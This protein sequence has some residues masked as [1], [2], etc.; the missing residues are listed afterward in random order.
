MLDLAAARVLQLVHRASA[1]TPAEI[2]VDAHHALARRAAA[3][4]IVL[5]RNEGGVLPLAGTGTVAVLGE[6]ARTP[7]YQGAGSS[8]VNPTRVDVALDA[9]TAALPEAT[10]RFA[11]GYPLD[12]PDG[13]ARIRS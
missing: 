11:A 5:L 4:C 9:L 13:G 10:V 3:E 7:R 12:D 6:L 8:Q 2:D 1:R